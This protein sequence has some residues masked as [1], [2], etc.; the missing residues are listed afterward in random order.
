MGP[1][2]LLQS[3]QTTSLVPDPKIPGHAGQAHVLFISSPYFCLI[4]YQSSTE[5]SV[6]SQTSSLPQR[7]ARIHPQGTR[8]SLSPP[9][10]G[11]GPPLAASPG[12][13]PS[14]H[15]PGLSP[16]QSQGSCGVLCLPSCRLTPGP[17]PPRA[18]RCPPP[19]SRLAGG[20][21]APDPP[22]RRGPDNN[23]A[24]LNAGRM[25]FSAAPSWSVTLRK[26]ETCSK[27]DRKRFGKKKKTKP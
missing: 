8:S 10:R 6:R 4:C 20:A 1:C 15:L 24:P 5:A 22:I 25:E 26:E 12:R 18:D 17:F 21:Q 16:A 3:L 13:S 14:I 7:L 27:R 2:P 19:S 9:C 11:A 23:R